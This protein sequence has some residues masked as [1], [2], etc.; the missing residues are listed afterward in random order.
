[1]G[2]ELQA[3]GEHRAIRRGDGQIHAGGE[4]GECARGPYG[5]AD[6]GALAG[7][8]VKVHPVTNPYA[9]AVTNSDCFI[10]ADPDR[11]G[12]T[13][14]QALTNRKAYVDPY[15]FSEAVTYAVTN[16]VARAAIAAVAETEPDVG[17]ERGTVGFAKTDSIGIT[18]AGSRA[19]RAGFA[20]I[21]RAA[22]R[23]A[24]ART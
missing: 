8:V 21:V 11:D 17:A 3:A 6:S 18:A 4:H 22:I 1:M 15:D 12:L 2:P 7:A 14:G 5:D 19:Q 9:Y 23:R 10:Y 16:S 24:D 13:D 20:S